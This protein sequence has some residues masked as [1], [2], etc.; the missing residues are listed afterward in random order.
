[1]VLQK[2]TAALFLALFYI[3]RL[4]WSHV[5]GKRIKVRV[6]SEIV[7]GRFLITFVACLL[8]PILLIANAFD[9]LRSTSLGSHASITYTFGVI[10]AVLG[11]VFMLLARMHRQKDW[12]FMGDDAGDVLFTRGIYSIS[13]HP[14]YVGA[15]SVGTGIY[16]ILNSWLVLCMLPVTFFIVHVIR[17][18]DVF[19]KNK[20]EAEWLAYRNRVGILTIN[21]KRS[22]KRMRQSGLKNMI[23]LARRRK[24]KH[25]SVG[26][27][28]IRYIDD[29]SI[30]T[31][32]E[33]LLALWRETESL[34]MS[35][36]QIDLTEAAF[37]R[38]LIQTIDAK[39]ILEAGT[40]RG[41]ST[42]VM[43]SAIEGEG[44]VV[45]M[46]IRPE[47]GELAAELWQRHLHPGVLAKI[48][49]RI[50]NA[51]TM[52]RDMVAGLGGGEHDCAGH[53]GEREGGGALFDLVFID[54]DKAGYPT[55]FAYAQKLVRKG[56][57]IIFDNALNAGLVA[58]KAEDRVTSVLRGLNKAAFSKE[59]IA[60]GFD[61]IVMPAWDGVVVLRKR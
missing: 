15:I 1:M 27:S 28:L 42:A 22:L 54:A 34:P 61:P 38:F 57:L 6:S 32:D 40:F 5:K 3:G 33:T 10:F 41:W 30:A 20:F 55:Y 24:N 11:L 47:E 35:N 21:M 29:L 26:K 56:G 43:A 48:D 19:L 36:M 25:I 31:F 59:T 45:T 23:L 9:I 4:A 51:V 18:E 17:E 39:N 2:V 13:R 49:Q 14:Y 53:V 37:L 44:K 8:V 60:E 7:T 46:Q 12:G 58:T 50:G 16:L 52:M